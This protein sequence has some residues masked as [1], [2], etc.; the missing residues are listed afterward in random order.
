MGVL[1]SSPK[2]PIDTVRPP[3]NIVVEDVPVSTSVRN[4]VSPKP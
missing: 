2:V 4:L 3:V 1:F